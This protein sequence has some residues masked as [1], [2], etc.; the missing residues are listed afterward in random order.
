MG[1]SMIHNGL[2]M[3]FEHPIFNTP[4]EY[5]EY[6]QIMAELAEE[7]EM[8]TPDPQPQDLGLNNNS[9]FNQKKVDSPKVQA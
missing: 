6:M 5:E 8:N 3:E 4:E 1:C 2:V 7:A 9:Y